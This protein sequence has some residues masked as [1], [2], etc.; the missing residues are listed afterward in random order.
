[1]IVTKEKWKNIPLLHIYNESM[2]N[3]SPVV[4]FLHGFMSAKEHNLHYAYQLVEKGVRVILPDAYLH[5]ER[6]AYLS[7][8]EMNLSFWKIVM[9]SVAEVQTL[10]QELRIRNLL[11]TDKVGIA[12]TSMGGIVTSGC[13]AVYD[14]VYTAGI[15]MGTVSYTKL[16]LHQLEDFAARG[17]SFPMSVEQKQSVFNMLEKYDLDRKPEVF[18]RC[19][20][21]FWHGMQD[22][23]V[24][25]EMSRPLYDTL[26]A[27]NKA[28]NVQ[29]LTEEKTGHA[30][31]R[32][33]MLEVT[34]WLTQ[35]L[36]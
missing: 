5:G 7:E 16:A 34:S 30:V 11:T 13:L 24:P 31:S 19:S 35:H 2:T 22:H 27:D 23:V 3:E 25:Y 12:G 6:T 17:I 4:F 10:Y 21:I 26:V 15:C 36:A 1:M 33:G 9:K 28:A 20:V 32:N 8:G 18:E 14:W 29:F